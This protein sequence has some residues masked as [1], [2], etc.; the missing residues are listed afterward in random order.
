MLKE[1]DR[2]RRQ[3][4]VILFFW[5]YFLHA[6]NTWYYLTKSLTSIKGTLSHQYFH[7]NLLSVPPLVW[8]IRNYYFLVVYL[9]NSNN[10]LQAVCANQIY[11]PLSTHATTFSLLQLCDTIFSGVNCFLAVS[12]VGMQSYYCYYSHY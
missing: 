4:V 10:Y 2:E 6:H 9:I 12:P 5:M 11:L 7:D 1:K 3:Q 8:S